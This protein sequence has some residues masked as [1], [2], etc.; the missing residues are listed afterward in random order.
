MEHRHVDDDPCVQRMVPSGC[1]EVVFYIGD[2]GVC[3]E[4]G[5]REERQPRGVVGGQ[6]TGNFD[7]LMGRQVH[8]YVATLLPGAARTLLGIPA[9]ELANSHVAVEDVYGPA[10]SEVIG[11]L[12]EAHDDGKRAGL[13]FDFFGRQFRASERGLDP[14]IVEGVERISSCGGIVRIEALARQLA[15]PRPK[16]ASF[17]AGTADPVAAADATGRNQVRLSLISG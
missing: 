5:A 11:R 12:M 10:G 9:D 17:C 8:F 4:P 15:S 14:R 6:R 2:Q 13:I 3:R 1:T 16:I 7:L